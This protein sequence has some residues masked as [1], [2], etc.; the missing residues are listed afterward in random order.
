LLPLLLLIML[1][2]LLTLTLTITMTL[3]TGGD[4]GARV[5]GGARRA[6]RRRALRARLLPM[7]GDC[8]GAGGRRRCDNGG[9]TVAGG[10]CR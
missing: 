1:M 4:C 2:M 9:R 8:S 6:R 3:T 5:C 7:V 10:G